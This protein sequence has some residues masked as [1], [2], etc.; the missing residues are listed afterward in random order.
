MS[1]PISGRPDPRAS[2]LPPGRTLQV[3]ATDPELA[4]AGEWLVTNTAD[5]GVQVRAGHG[6]SDAAL[7]GRAADVLLV[8]VGRRPAADPSVSVFGDSGLLD[9]WLAGVTF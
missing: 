9:S 1:G 4:G 8:L 6:D 5:D 7:S 3:H 2:A